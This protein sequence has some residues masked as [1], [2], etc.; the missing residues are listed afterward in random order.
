MSLLYQQ[1]VAV[2]VNRQVLFILQL[3]ELIAQA[4][5]VIVQCPIFR[6]DFNC[7]FVILKARAAGLSFIYFE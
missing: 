5:D 3:S 1:M 6:K 4:F 7:R 2:S